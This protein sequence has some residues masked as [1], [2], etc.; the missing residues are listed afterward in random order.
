M[1]HMCVHMYHKKIKYHMLGKKC[2]ATQNVMVACSFDIYICLG[3][4]RR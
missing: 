2:V 4:M 3:W 1:A